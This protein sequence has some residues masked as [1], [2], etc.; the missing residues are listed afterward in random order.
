MLRNTFPSRA[1]RRWLCLATLLVPSALRAQALTPPPL[2]PPAPPPPHL[3]SDHDSTGFHADLGLV[4]TSGNTQVTTLDFADALTFHTSPRNKIGQSFG[5]VYG[6]V[7]HKVQTSL[8]VAG[9]RDGYTFTPTIA[10]FAL[11]NF[12][13]NTFAGIDRRFEEGAGTTVM[14]VAAKRDR[15]EIDLG[16]S[17]LEE[18]STE[19]VADNFPAA[20]GALDYRH[21]FGKN[22]YFEQTVAGIPD[23]SKASNYQVNSQSSLVAPLSRFLG[24]KIGYTIRYSNLPPP[25][26]KTTDRLLTSDIQLTL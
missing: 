19:G 20:R 8:W 3:P 26:F 7:M 2:V 1:T 4:N 16:G 22:E 17:Y 5:V 23:V 12:D 21:A 14:A 13:R 9:L 11:V 18:V 6:T 15:L 10:V 24:I 25:G